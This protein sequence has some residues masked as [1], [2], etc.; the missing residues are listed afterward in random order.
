MSLLSKLIFRVSQGL[1]VAEKMKKKQVCLVLSFEGGEICQIEQFSSII[2]D[3]C[4]SE[5]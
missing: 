3:V 5:K 2:M 4:I 1:T